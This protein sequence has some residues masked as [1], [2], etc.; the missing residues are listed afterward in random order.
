MSVKTLVKEIKDLLPKKGGIN[1]R[2]EAAPPSRMCVKFGRK[3]TLLASGP[4]MSAASVSQTIQDC[5]QSYG[6]KNVINV[7]V[8]EDRF[9]VFGC[10][11]TPPPPK[12]HKLAFDS[13]IGLI[14][15]ER[16]YQEEVRRTHT[17]SDGAVHAPGE[18]ILMAEAYINEARTNWV[19]KAGYADAM[20]SLRKVAAI[21]VQ[22][23][24]IYGARRRRVT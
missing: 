15:D 19:T 10:R 1:P 7:A 24:E 4:V 23:M 2:I 8:E 20:D 12:D 21:C 3:L 9:F 16:G 14:A 22:A 6:P 11:S 5:A 17:R 13:V 18:F